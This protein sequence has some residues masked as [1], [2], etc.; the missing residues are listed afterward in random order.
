[1][2]LSKI[3]KPDVPVSLYHPTIGDVEWN[4]LEGW[5]AF[6]LYHTKPNQNGHFDTLVVDESVLFDED[7]KIKDQFNKEG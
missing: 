7:W 5:G 3:V 2:K 1:M 4:Y 6:V